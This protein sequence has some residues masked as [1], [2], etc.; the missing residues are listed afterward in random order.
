MSNEV[1][2]LM[3]QCDQ[4]EYDDELSRSAFRRSEA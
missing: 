1:C 4:D 2:F 3:D